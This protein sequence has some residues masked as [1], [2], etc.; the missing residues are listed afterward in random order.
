MAGSSNNVIQEWAF[1][2]LESTFLPDVMSYRLSST[3]YIAHLRRIPNLIVDDQ[4]YV[5]RCSK[6]R[7]FCFGC[8]SFRQ[9]KQGFEACHCSF[10]CAMLWLRVLLT[11][12]RDVNAQQTFSHPERADWIKTGYCKHLPGFC[13]LL[14]HAC[15]F[16]GGSDSWVTKAIWGR[17]A[18]FKNRAQ[19]HGMIPLHLVAW[20]QPA[21]PLLCS[22]TGDPAKWFML[23]LHRGHPPPFLLRI[24][25][26]NFWI[27]FFSYT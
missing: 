10:A 14:Y 15:K 8:F 13:C 7:C 12:S 24:I 19:L 26:G 20:Q 23:Q 5:D 1:C 17:F 22:S 21:L 16:L 11:E 4:V 9:H 27:V 18:V 2:A 3:L 25:L 6:R